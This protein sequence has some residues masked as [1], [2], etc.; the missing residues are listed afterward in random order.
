M[1]RANIK[2][3]AWIQ[4]RCLRNWLTNSTLNSIKKIAKLCAFQNVLMPLLSSFLSKDK[5][6]WTENTGSRCEWWNCL[7]MLQVY[8]ITIST[9][10]P[11]L[12]AKLASLAY[13]RMLCFRDTV[14]IHWLIQFLAYWQHLP[15]RT[16][17]PTTYTNFTGS[18]LSK[19]I[20][21]MKQNCV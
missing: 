14:S 20:E 8:T 10:F 12:L 7:S 11:G 17:L 18:L 3:L 5:C 1:V 15:Q 19:I 2:V 9:L 13:V 4:R 21:L 6:P 16:Q